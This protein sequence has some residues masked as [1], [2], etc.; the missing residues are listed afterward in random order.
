LGVCACDRLQH[1]N[2]SQS[3]NVSVGEFLKG[4]FSDSF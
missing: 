1:Q 2:L 3:S 4:W